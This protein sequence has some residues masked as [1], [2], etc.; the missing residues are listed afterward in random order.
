MSRALAL[1]QPV[2]PETGDAGPVRVLGDDGMVRELDVVTLA[3]TRDAEGNE[4]TPLKPGS[5]SPDGRTAAFAQTGEVVVVGLTDGAVRRYP[6]TGYLEHVVWAGTGCWSG[7]TTPRTSWTGAQGR[8]GSSRSTRGRSSCPNRPGPV[9]CSLWA[10]G[11]GT[12]AWPYAGSPPP[13][14]RRSDGR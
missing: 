13:V 12:A 2:D 3:P 8:R 5:L 11:P 10:A 14:A 4:A 7:T 6:L 1:Y 9:T